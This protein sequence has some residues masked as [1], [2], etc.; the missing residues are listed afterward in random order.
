MRLS[1]K[2]RVET[3]MR[4]ARH[5]RRWPHLFNFYAGN[6]PKKGKACRACVLA[7]AGVLLGMKA[8]DPAGDLERVARVLGFGRAIAGWYSTRREPDEVVRL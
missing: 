5:I 1:K 8:K 6:I 2:R 7:R 3:L 4:A